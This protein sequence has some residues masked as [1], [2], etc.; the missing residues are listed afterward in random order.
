MIGK[1]KPGIETMARKEIVNGL[2]SSEIEKQYG[3]RVH[4]S[5]EL[6][7]RL[8]EDPKGDELDAVLCG[9]QGGWAWLQRV[10]NCQV[11]EAY[12]MIEGWIIDP[13]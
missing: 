8:V 13:L 3:L 7:E 6:S 2:R 4:L 12:K 1:N 10:D 9:V 11:E 5:D